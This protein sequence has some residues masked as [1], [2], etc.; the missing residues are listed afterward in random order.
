MSTDESSFAAL[1]TLWVTAPGKNAESTRVMITSCNDQS[2]ARHAFGVCF[3]MEFALAAHV[4]SGVSYDEPVTGLF[5]IAMLNSIEQSFF[6]GEDIQL[7]GA[8]HRNGQC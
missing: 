4:V 5:S 2:A 7:Y 3:G 1:W 8:Y 6:P